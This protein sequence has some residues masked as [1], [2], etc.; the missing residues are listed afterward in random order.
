[1]RSSARNWPERFSGH[2]APRQS[3]GNITGVTAERVGRP[4]ENAPAVLTV[5]T[6][7]PP[8]VPCLPAAYVSAS[9]VRPRP[10]AAFTLV[11]LLVVIAIIAVLM[12]LLLPAMQS[13]R[14]AARRV[15]CA[16]NLRQWGIALH[17]HADGRRSLPPG[18]NYGSTSGPSGINTTGTVGPN[19][20]WRRETF[21]VHLWPYIEERSL[22]AA[23]D[24]RFTFYAQTNRAAVIQQPK[25][26]SCASDFAR[27][28]KGDEYVRAK[29][30]YVVS[31]GRTDWLQE[32]EPFRSVFGAN[33]RTR[34]QQITDGIS[35]TV[36]MS[37]I[38]QGGTDT[39]FD[40]R[41]DFLNSDSSC[42]SFMTMNTPNTGIDRG[43]CVNT[44]VPAPCIPTKGYRTSVSARSRHSGGVGALYGDGATRF[45]PDGIDV[46][47]WQAQSTMNAGD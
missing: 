10:A 4:S 29:G 25:L 28:W 33:R 27:P 1:M 9:Y 8:G 22:A 31:W 26:Y 24:F 47:V 40:F 13:A 11:E 44:A 19:D 7:S 35:R 14:E 46:S 16:N 37:E 5:S 18:A 43:I 45:I 41:G 17:L 3:H 30:N 21:V 36:F 34:L 42:Q 23:Y 6:P 32:P 39:E 12:G 2:R 38:I 20:E 15:S